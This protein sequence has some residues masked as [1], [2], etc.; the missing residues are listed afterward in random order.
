MGGV[1]SSHRS[2]LAWTSRSASPGG[3]GRYPEGDSI[4]KASMG[5]MSMSMLM[6][7]QALRAFLEETCGTVAN[8]FDVMAGLALRA[9]MGGSGNPQD[10]IEYMFRQEEL[11][12]TLKG[13]GYGV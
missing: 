4:S 2:D 5:E 9:S 10:R 3:A 6:R 1:V 8:A 12:A 11:T 7:R 13:L